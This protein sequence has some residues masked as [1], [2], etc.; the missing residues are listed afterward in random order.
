MDDGPE[1]AIPQPGSADAAGRR[2]VILLTGL[3]GAGMSTALKG[4]EDLGHE[5]VDNLPLA[6][7]PGLVAEGDGRGRPLAVVIDCRTRD[8][9]ADAFLRQVDRLGARPDLDVRLVFVTADT[10]V[11]Q[12]RFTE[13]RRRHPL[14]L[15]RPIADGIQA[16]LALLAPVAERA[17]L[18]IDTSLL[19]LHELKRMIAGHFALDRQPGLL[20]SVVSFSFRRGLPREADLVFDVRFL[21]NPYWDLGLRAFSG[22]DRPVQDFVAADPDF[23]G[24]MSSL[25]GLIGPLLPRYNR[26]GKSYLTV[27]IGCTGGR[28]RSVFVAER[29]AQWLRDD[30]YRVGLAHRD[31]AHQA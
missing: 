21:D 16:E 5:A 7:V 19:N 30:G 26:E 25:K 10:E 4:L 31:L 14:A 3:S 17:D 20:V 13:T 18:V 24:F 9:A 27:A 22:L 28:H 1:A 11:L 12:R 6:L 15:D 2:Q 29:V 23:E 8:F